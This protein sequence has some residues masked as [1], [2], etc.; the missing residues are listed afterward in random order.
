MS[1]QEISNASFKYGLCCWILSFFFGIF[2]QAS[3]L[4]T[5]AYSTVSLVSMIIIV[6]L[7]AIVGI[8]VGIQSIKSNTYSIKTIIGLVLCFP[9]LSIASWLLYEFTT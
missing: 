3:G 2:F 7:I 4:I 8:V 5:S 6:L 1:V 9:P